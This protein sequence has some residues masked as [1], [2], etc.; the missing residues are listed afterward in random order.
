MNSTDFQYQY[1]ASST[2]ARE[3]AAS[4]L[5]LAHH[6]E[7]N[8]VN[9]V[10]CFF[11][12]S[13]TEPYLTARCWITLAK[14]VRSSFGLM[15]VSLRDPIVS[16]GAE[17][18]RFEGFSSCNGVYVRLDML[19]EA[20]DGEYVASGT[21][22]VDFNEPMIHA[23]NLVQKNERVVL[24]VGQRDVSVATEKAK[25]IEKK[26]ALP[27]RWIKGLTNV[28]VSLARMNQLFALNRVQC[29][30]LFQ[31]VPKGNAKG[32][33][34][35]TFR[36][37]KYSLS[38]LATPG[39]VRIGGIQR[40]RLLEGILPWVQQMHLYESEDRE[41]CAAVADFGKMRL[42]MAFSPDATRGFSSEGS[43]LESL[44]QQ[45]S[46]EWVHGLNYLLKSN[47]TFD[48]TLVSIENDVDFGTMDSLVAHLSAMGLLGY[49][50]FERHHFYR[51]LPFKTERILGLNP[52]LKNAQ[53][54]VSNDD[55]VILDN[56]AGHVE[57]RVKGTGVFH[58]V[59]LH[60]N[61]AK[62]TCQWFT[63]YQGKRGLCKHVLAVQ[64]VLDAG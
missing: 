15:P 31:A 8:E 23:L 32:T 43:A 58:T 63:S 29:I 14:V 34:Y 18:L 27:N 33:Y 41:T 48:P 35:I 16:V 62:C 24:G 61:E 49:D 2:L 11:W 6:S 4:L 51:R 47:E 26:V 30:Q 38:T 13:L 64:M 44:A 22:N 36:S 54:L 37:G 3:G 39:S 7:I 25:V 56:R 46:N 19:P 50:V 52:R 59:L 5:K 45:V 40:L 53:Q 10:P 60:G 12:G 21:T 42:M 9:N 20:V 28:Q 55:I 1:A 17:K 57:A